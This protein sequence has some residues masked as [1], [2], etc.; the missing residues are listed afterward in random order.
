[1]PGEPDTQT[2]VVSTEEMNV[3]QIF[4]KLKDEGILS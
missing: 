1:M 2:I 4:S 3:E